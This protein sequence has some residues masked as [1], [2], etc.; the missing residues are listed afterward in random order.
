MV[1]FLPK[2]KRTAFDANG[3]SAEGVLPEELTRSGQCHDGTIKLLTGVEG[4]TGGFG[5][6]HVEAKPERLKGISSLGF[7]TV[8]AYPRYIFADMTHIGLQEDGRIVVIREDVSSFHHVI[9]QWDQ[10]LRIWS[11]TTIIPKRHA[12]GI[13]LIWTKAAR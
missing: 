9:C 8:H 13:N 6:A 5:L 11:V 12:R 3:K 1:I 10:D 7:K 4:R 2:E